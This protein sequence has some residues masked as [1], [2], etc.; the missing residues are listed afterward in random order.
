MGVDRNTIAWVLY[1]DGESSSNIFR[2]DINN[3]LACTATSW[4]SQDGLGEFGMGFST[5]TSGGTTDTLYVGGGAIGDSSMSS[6][7]LA[8]LNTST[9]AMATVGT[10][11]G[12][13][14]MTGTGTAQLWGFLPSSSSSII[15]IN[16]TSGSAITTFNESGT[17]LSGSPA[18]WAF[19]FYGGDF[20]VFLMKD[21]DLSTNIYQVTGS[22]AGSGA[23]VNTIATPI[24]TEIVGAG[25]STCAP[26]T[27]E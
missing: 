1:S 26:I 4:A 16:K 23:I 11:G 14:E 12:W 15:Q 24:G 25:V 17:A 27:I 8:T 20:W 5:D 21:S 19:A 10:I 3:S 7:T 2:V 9:M 13:P 22:G 18:A 6:S